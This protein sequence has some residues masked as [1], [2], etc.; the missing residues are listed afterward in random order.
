MYNLSIHV[1]GWLVG[2]ACGSM[3]QA[4]GRKFTETLTDE[5]F[6]RFVK[7][8]LHGK[9]SLIAFSIK[10]LQNHLA[11]TQGSNT[12]FLA[13]WQHPVME[14]IKEASFILSRL[15]RCLMHFF[16]EDVPSN[17]SSTTDMDIRIITEY[18]GPCIV[19][20]AGK[21]LVTS[22][23]ELQFFSL[24]FDRTYLVVC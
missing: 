6:L 15:A 23:W 11:L 19:T 20:K 17:V 24:K 2:L 1:P 9:E 8:G 16:C 10:V 4:I 3:W 13:L 18:K 22:H 14:T 7:Q 12:K 21:K 5:S